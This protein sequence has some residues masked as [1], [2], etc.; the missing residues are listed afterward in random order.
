M[1]IAMIGQKGVPSHFGGIETHV[2][3]LA[4]RLVREG[5]EVFA[6]ARPWYSKEK[7]NKFN[8]INIK[9][10]P[11]INT[12]HLDAISHTF[13]SI[14][15]ACFVLRPDVIHI[16]GVGPSLLSWLPKILRPNAVVISTFHCIDRHHAKWGS[17]AREAL[18]LGEKMSVRHSDETIAVSK[19]LTNYIALNYG[20]RVSHIPNGITPVRVSVDDIVLEPFGLRSYGYISMVSRLVKHKGVHTLID[21]WKLARSKNPQALKDLK[22]AIV[23]G[24]AF[25]DDYVEALHKQAE[26]DDSIV[27][28]GY[29]TGEALEALFAG[30]KFIVHP[31]TSEGLP[32]SVLEAMSYGKAVIASDIPENMEVV[33]DHGVPFTTGSVDELAETII[34]LAS[35]DMLTASIGHT[36]REFVETEYN[37]DDIGALTLEI[38]EKHRALREGVL[39]TN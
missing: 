19:V 12:K 37:W 8:G 20:E 2:T 3:E 14:L 11:S 36:A 13:L 18:K 17:I 4:T 22:L 35:D 23:G 29:Q 9:L 26:G 34:E 15:H 28:T 24:S 33:K 21:A 38:Y 32:I 5:H 31:S 39:A 25:T 7:S 6:Y 10:L 1:K 27:F 16:H 30:S